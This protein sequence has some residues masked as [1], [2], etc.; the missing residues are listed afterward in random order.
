MPLLSA[1]ISDKPTGSHAIERRATRYWSSVVWRRE[2]YTPTAASATRYAITIAAS[3]PEKAVRMP[4]RYHS[5]YDR[6]PMTR[7]M[8]ALL[9][10]RS[11]VYAAFLAS[12]TLGLFFIFVWTPL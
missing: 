9:E 4:E 8:A 10:R 3:S 6:W 2:K 12:L 5:R 1:A 11:T 7:L